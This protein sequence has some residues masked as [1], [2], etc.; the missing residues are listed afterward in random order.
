WIEIEDWLN[1]SLALDS[2][3]FSEGI[4]QTTNVIDD[5]VVPAYVLTRLVAHKDRDDLDDLE[6]NLIQS[7]PYLQSAV[8]MSVDVL[9]A[10][11]VDY[12]HHT[13]LRLLVLEVKV[14]IRAQFLGIGQGHCADSL[15]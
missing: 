8:D 6:N 5:E 11:I 12:T 2:V 4:K 13:I 7:N 9:T 1:S 14:E 10:K 3:H 15:K